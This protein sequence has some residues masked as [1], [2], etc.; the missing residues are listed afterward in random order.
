M[1]R[2]DIEEEAGSWGIEKEAD[3]GY[4]HTYE[5]TEVGLGRSYVFLPSPPPPPLT[6]PLDVYD[7]GLGRFTGVGLGYLLPVTGSGEGGRDWGRERWR[8]GLGE[9]EVLGRL[10]CLQV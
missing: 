10:T 5:H 8:K 6:R 2:F 7:S 1:A 4:E 3:D 9:G